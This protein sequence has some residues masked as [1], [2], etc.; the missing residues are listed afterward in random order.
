MSQN[1]AFSKLWSTPARKST[2]PPV[3][4]LGLMPAMVLR[5]QVCLCPFLR[6][7]ASTVCMCVSE[8]TV[9]TIKSF[10]NQ[11][12]PLL[13]YGA[14]T[15]L[16]VWVREMCS[17]RR[18]GRS[19]APMVFLLS[20]RISQSIPLY[21]VCI[22]YLVFCIVYFS[23]LCILYLFWMEWCTY[24]LLPF[25]QIILL[26]YSELLSEHLY[27]MCVQFCKVC[28]WVFS[29]LVV[30]VEVISFLDLPWHENGC[31]TQIRGKHALLC[32]ANKKVGE[33]NLSPIS[34]SCLTSKM[35]PPHPH[36]PR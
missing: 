8:R 33:I 35:S 7:G 36:E 2:P 26:Q 25:P 19:G 21:F 18:T 34:C 22:L 20:H 10:F 5:V 17:L 1:F 16:C 23:F 30:F 28:L 14:S 32:G 29:N 27:F 15:A 31:T 6:W 4:R 9:L 11:T 24:G 3:V 12:C 13:R